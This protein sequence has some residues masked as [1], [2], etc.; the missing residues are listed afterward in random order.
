MK[1]MDA[2]QGASPYRVWPA[3][4]SSFSTRRMSAL[5]HNI[6]EHPLFQ[7]SALQELAHELMPAGQCRFLR[8]GATQG[9]AF[10]HDAAHPQ[11]LS[12]DEVFARM[13]EPGSWLALYNVETVARYQAALD[14]I[15]D[16]LRPVIE[17]E[18]PGI[19]LV[20]GF[21]F[22]SA[23]PSVTPFHIDRENNFWLQLRG[24]KTMNVWDCADREV[25]PAAGVESF[26]ASGIQTPYQ[27]S[28]RA[29]SSEFN[30]GPGDGVYF[31]STS[32]HMTKTDTSWARPGDGISISLGV[33]F[34]TSVTRRTAQVHQF[35]R[36]LR[37]IG[38]SPSYPGQSLAVDSLKAPLG[39]WVA[40][41][42]YRRL[43]TKAPPGAY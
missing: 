6:N 40:A 17:P 14:R 8:P 10:V 15:V 35:N 33:N 39:H 26:I 2:E 32:P 5:R 23:P 20:T 19:F 29:R 1:S 4:P 42:R 28:F 34:Y 12:I 27:E 22:I 31:P 13:E 25:I 38:M 30:T 3:E 11:G 24:R 21:I 18:Q 36:V 37:R 43:G 16:D 7:L 41:T 9:S